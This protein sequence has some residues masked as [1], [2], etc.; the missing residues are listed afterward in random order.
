M[1]TNSD[2]TKKKTRAKNP[3]IG[4]QA[5]PTTLDNTTKIDI[6]INKELMDDIIV[7]GLSNRLD[8]SALDNFTTIA[9]SRDQIYQLIDTMMQDSAVSSVVRTYTEDV[10]NVADN[11]HI[12]WAE[13]LD[14][15]ISKF[16]NYLL[17]VMNADKKLPGWV[18]SLIT[19]GDLYLRLGRESDYED[20]FFK[21]DKIDSV[22]ST[23]NIL[24]EE[25]EQNFDETYQEAKNREKDLTES[26]RMQ[27]RSES[28][29]YSY[30]VEQVADPSTMF[31]LVRFGK[32]CGYIETPNTK[33]GYNFS[34]NIN[35]AG[36]TTA[37]V[38]N[39]KMKSNEVTLY[40][41]DDFVHAYLLDNISRFPET[42]DLFIED[43]DISSGTKD[44]ASASS[45]FVRRGKSMLYDSYKIWREKSLLE[46]AILLTRVTRSSLIQKVQV[47]VGDMSKEQA[48][49]VLRNVKQMFEQKTSLDPNTSMTDYTNPGAVVNYV[50]FTTHGGQGAVSVESI[51]GDVNIKD[52]ADLDNW[53]NKFYASFGIPKQYFG[54]TDDAA[55][56][57]GGTSL[58]LI[59]SVYANGVKKI[60][61]AIIQAMSDLISLFLLDRGY[62][63]YLNQFVLKMKAPVTQEEKDYRESLTNQISAVS[64]L[65]SLFADI[66]DK[67]RKLKLLKSSLAGLN[68]GDDMLTI[69]QEEIDE[70]ELAKK[71]AEEEET[72]GETTEGSETPE[73]EAPEAPA[74]EAGGT[75][76]IDLGMSSVATEEG[77]NSTAGQVILTENLP[78]LDLLTEDDDLPAP[79]DL[80]KN[81]DFTKNV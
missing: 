18:Y 59:S 12:I 65:Q 33:V 11:G 53:I 44:T 49:K 75:E 74:E 14:P 45:Y 70:A 56:F 62:K 81:I 57:N 50:Y 9:N 4:S 1:P 39:Y 64:N 42:V 72:A 73:L 54:N 16:V 28:D 69:I 55:G 29:H 63:S 32:T 15:K 48:R 8:T 17:N 40:Q 20:K 19:Y 80:D 13:S 34:E 76:D 66:E 61:N 71:K 22:Y 24:N 77:F 10:C 5:Q 79:E 52:L 7:A 30:Y 2:T 47:E 58:A 60:Q 27:L 78:D 67:P 23:R 37:T 41:A 31:E 6:D 25:L 36:A 21:K 26:V 51:G 46:S 38:A 68:Y 43:D 35:M 3:L